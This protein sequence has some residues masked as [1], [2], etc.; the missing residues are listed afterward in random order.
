MFFDYVIVGP[1][2]S[3][4]GTAMREYRLILAETFNLITKE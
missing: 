1:S 3:L 4:Q 2:V